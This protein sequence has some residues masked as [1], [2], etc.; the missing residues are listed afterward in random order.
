MG[1][2]CRFMEI[3]G[4]TKG[5]LH[6]SSVV[7]AGWR[8]SGRDAAPLPGPPVA[9]PVLGSW[10]GMTPSTPAAGNGGPAVTVSVSVTVTQ[11]NED[12]SQSPAGGE[13]AAA[14]AGTA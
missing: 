3:S 1:L 12:G 10:A 13:L 6:W 4:V 5:D 8:G 9:G 7:E 11:V 14:L 2:S